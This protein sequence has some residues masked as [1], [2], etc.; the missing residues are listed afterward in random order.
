MLDWNLDYELNKLSEMRSAVQV[1]E[2]ALD[3]L[4]V[5]LMET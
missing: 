1:R 4:K 3:F 5:T 2:T